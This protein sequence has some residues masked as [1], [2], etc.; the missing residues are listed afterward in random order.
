MIFL[1]AGA[2]AAATCARAR[3]TLETQEASV[4]SAYKGVM[5]VPHGCEPREPTALGS[6]RGAAYCAADHR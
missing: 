3:I 1:A 4:G 5:R 2:F 6:D